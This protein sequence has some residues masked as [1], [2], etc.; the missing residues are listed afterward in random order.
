[1]SC[2]VSESKNVI[3]DNAYARK[4]KIPKRN[5]NQAVKEI[6]DKLRN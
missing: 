6:V 5:I 1:M 3:E 4:I 2:L